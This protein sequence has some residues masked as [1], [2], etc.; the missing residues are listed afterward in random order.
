MTVAT[1]VCVLVVTQFIMYRALTNSLDDIQELKD[2]LCSLEQ[3]YDQLSKKVRE[4]E[5]N[6]YM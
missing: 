6:Q 2:K 3:E 4:V 5:I 1:I